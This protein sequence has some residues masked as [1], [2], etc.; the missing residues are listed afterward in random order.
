MT[1]RQRWALAV[2]ALVAPD[3]RVARDPDATD[4]RDR[5]PVLRELGE[6]CEIE[7]DDISDGR[8]YAAGMTARALA[9]PEHV[10]N[11]LPWATDLGETYVAP[12]Q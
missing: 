4:D 6:A 10:W 8:A 1:E 5:A 7:L 3:L 2:A 11:Q 9:D 12:P